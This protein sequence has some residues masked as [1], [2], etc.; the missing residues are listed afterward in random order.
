MY[1]GSYTPLRAGLGNY[2]PGEELFVVGGLDYRLNPATALSFDL[3][4]TR[5]SSDQLEGG[6]TFEAGDK[7]TGAVQLRQLFGFHELRIAAR[8]RTRSNSTLVQNELGRELATVPARADLRMTFRLRVD[9]TLA[10][11]FLLQGRSYGSTQNFD[12]QHVADLGIA[13]S[14]RV[15]D[16]LTV[17]SRFR[18]TVGTFNGLQAGLGMLVG[19]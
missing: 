17:Q 2:D 10:A 12:A 14:T 3:T 9:D 8:Y 13:P 15:T 16:N 6:R 4:Y 19:W 18:Y 1:R 11:Q 7:L 5:Y